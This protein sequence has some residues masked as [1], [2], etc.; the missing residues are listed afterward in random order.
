MNRRRRQIPFPGDREEDEFHSQEISSERMQPEPRSNYTLHSSTPSPS[1][2]ARAELRT[3]STLRRD[4]AR[5]GLSPQ[6]G[7][8]WR[9]HTPTP[10]GTT[11]SPSSRRSM[12]SSALPPSPLQPVRR[13]HHSLRSTTSL[14]LR[15]FVR[16]YGRAV[17]QSPRQNQLE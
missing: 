10:M 11:L 5:A 13:L 1:D 12:R 3:A 9:Q 7:S 15:G 8:H 17:S 16:N 14:P 2:K 6:D 4:K